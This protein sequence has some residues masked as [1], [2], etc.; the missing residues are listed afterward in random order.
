MSARPKPWTVRDIPPQAGKLAIVTGA[1]SG[2]GYDTALELARAG[3]A[4]VV[5]SRSE[6]K[7]SAAVSRIQAAVPGAEVRFEA[8]DLASLVAVAGFAERI[9][10]AGRPVDILVNN[11]GVMMLPQR[12]LTADGFEMQL[13]TNFLG[14]FALTGHLLPLLVKAHARVVQVS[15][16]AHRRGKI[17][18]DDLQSAQRYGPSRAYSQSKLAML[19]FALELQRRSDAGG[20]G[21]T[22][23][24][25][26]PGVAVSELVT[27]GLGSSLSGRGMNLVQ[28]VIGQPTAA[29]ALPTL[30]AA[31]A[32]VTPGGYYGPQG[33]LEIRGAPGPAKAEPQALDVAAARRLWDVAAELTGVHFA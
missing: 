19:M 17:D 26:H 12:Q 5:A 29:G 30:Y 4:V 9:L 28:K 3:A 16:I 1:N 13:G 32:K 6:A 24:A 20:W 11:A 10:G 33:L 23:V 15:S 22:S 18:F 31:T 21:L 8:L 14:H 25:A 7:G 2:I 27:N